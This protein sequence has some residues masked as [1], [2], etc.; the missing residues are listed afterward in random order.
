ME[1]GMIVV[2]FLLYFFGFL[3]ALIVT[4]GNYPDSF[5]WPIL[6]IKFMIKSIWSSLKYTWKLIIR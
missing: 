6:F 4:G 1:Q 5:L 2:M 3:A